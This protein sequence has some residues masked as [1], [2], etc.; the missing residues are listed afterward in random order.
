MSSFHLSN[1]V[2]QIRFC[3]SSSLCEASSLSTFLII[4]L[5]IGGCFHGFATFWPNILVYFCKV[6]LLIVV[7]G[8]VNF[9]DVLLN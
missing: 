1:C 2:I 7:D 6:L 5:E 9:V 4:T 8:R 3:S